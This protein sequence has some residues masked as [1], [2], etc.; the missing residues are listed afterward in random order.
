MKTEGLDT[1]E[2]LYEVSRIPQILAELMGIPGI[3][4]DSYISPPPMYKPMGK[5][6]LTHY[7]TLVPMKTNRLEFKI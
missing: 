6:Y 7:T 4:K 3:L 2:I 1:F 5:I